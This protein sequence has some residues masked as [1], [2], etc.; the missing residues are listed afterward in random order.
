MGLCGFDGG[1]KRDAA[2]EAY[3]SSDAH[4][5]IVRHTRGLKGR[6]GEVKRYELVQ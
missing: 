6:R 1:R 3:R 2:I 5:E 4:K